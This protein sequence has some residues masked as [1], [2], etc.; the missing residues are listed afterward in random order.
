[1]DKKTGEWRP[2]ITLNTIA[3]HAEVWKGD[4]EFDDFVKEQQKDLA[5]FHSM[6]S[7]WAASYKSNVPPSLVEL[8]D[9]NNNFGPKVLVELSRDYR[10]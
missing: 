6:I 3:E 9:Y 7:S 2:Q 8:R 5:Y 4:L 10:I 1:M